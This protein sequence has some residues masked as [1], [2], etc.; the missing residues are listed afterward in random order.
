[1][2]DQK[3]EPFAGGAGWK[4]NVSEDDIVDLRRNLGLYGLDAMRT[5]L[6][7]SHDYY[8]EL[9]KIEPT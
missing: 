4:A 5:T 1:M 7:V 6:L 8:Y 3:Y 9:M 2:L